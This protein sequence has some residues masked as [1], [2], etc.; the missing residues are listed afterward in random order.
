MT[1]PVSPSLTSTIGSTV[2]IGSA[3]DGAV[4]GGDA[5][6]FS[7]DT[8]L[9]YCQSRL[10]DLDS[11]INQTA[12]QQQVGIQER[13]AI[14]TALTQM[15]QFNP[16]GPTNPQNMT[17]CVAAV[18]TAL[19]SFPADDPARAQLQS[20]LQQMETTYNYQPPGP[21]A[22]REAALGELLDEQ[23]SAPPAAYDSYTAR[24]DS[25]QDLI[26]NGSFSAPSDNASDHWTATTTAF[27]NVSSD[28]QDQ[29]EMNF[30]QLQDL[31]SQRQQ[32]VELSTGM[33]NKVDQTLEDQA[34]AV[35][36]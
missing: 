5:T 11:Q 19:A 34:K 12:N 15:S 25:A 28:I 26:A 30:L 18:N 1:M 29:S 13:A 31:V 4:A 20:A 33:M 24:I 2:P 23:S 35:G 14:Q 16:G 27:S 21:T 10:G 36:Q 17:A 32:A 6:S 22:D 9:A 3:S 7:P 8:L